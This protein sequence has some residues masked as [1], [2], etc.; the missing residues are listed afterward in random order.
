MGEPDAHRERAK[1]APWA[2]QTL[3]A[4]APRESQMRIASEPDAH[5]ARTT[6][7]PNTHRV[8]TVGEP[9]MHRLTRT[10]MPT[11]NTG[12]PVQS[13]R[14]CLGKK[15]QRLM[16]AM[17]CAPRE[18]SHGRNAMARCWEASNKPKPWT[19]RHGMGSHISVGKA[20]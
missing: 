2:S 17:P 1:C 11:H 19:P 8:R 16:D 20:Y 12:E 10:K 6:G 7:E 15:R 13:T 14:A 4:R 9:D 18:I 5:C 3:N